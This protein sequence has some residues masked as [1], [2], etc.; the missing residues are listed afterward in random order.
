MTQ[1]SDKT[2]GVAFH[3]GICWD[4]SEISFARFTEGWLL[5]KGFSDDFE[6]GLRGWTVGRGDISVSSEIK[7]SGKFA[8]KINDVSRDRPTEVI[9]NIPLLVKGKMNFWVF[10]DN[11]NSGF[12]FNLGD[13]YAE[14]NSG[15]WNKARFSFFVEPDGSL[16]WRDGSDGSLKELPVVADLPLKIWTNIE[17]NWDADSDSI[18]VFIDGDSK[19]IVC[20]LYTS[21]SPRDLSTSRMPSSA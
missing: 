8:L 19:G 21:P 11:L 2:I 1:L 15:Y 5:E 14:M 16:K 3:T 6:Q 18:E 20:L 17:L 12:G 7:K 10:L 13:G 9:H 4:E